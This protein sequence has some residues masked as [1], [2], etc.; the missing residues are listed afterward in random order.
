MTFVKI[1]PWLIL[2]LIFVLGVVT[3]VSLTVGLGPHFMRPPGA[4]Q[5]KKRML[6]GLTHRLNLT[7]DQ[8]ARIDPILANAETQIQALHRDEVGRISR[9][10]ETVNTQILPL[11]TPEQQTELQKMRKEMEGQRDRMFPGHMRPWMQ[12]GQPPPP[13]G[14][15][16]PPNGPPPP[17]ST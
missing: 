9:I 2:A 11:L 16:P 1:K 7:A 5:M 10:M 8:Q 14:G 13:A 4:Q 6:M 15:T 12:P 17:P 3:G